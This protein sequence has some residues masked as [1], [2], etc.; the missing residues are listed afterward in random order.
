MTPIQMFMAA[1]RFEKTEHVPVAGA[2]TEFYM[3]T[4][5]SDLEDMPDSARQI[6]MLERADELFPGIPIIFVADPTPCL[7]P[8]L[9]RNLREAAD[10][11]P[12]SA[13]VFRRTKLPDPDSTPENIARLREIVFISENMPERLKEQYGYCRGLVRFE[14]P[15]DNL[16]E[17]VGSSDWFLKIKSDPDFIEAAMELFT[18]MSVAGARWLAA[19]IGAP[20]RVILAEDFPGMISAAAFSRFVAPFHRRIFDT[21]PDALKILHNDSRTAH[22]LD[23]LPS[24]GM[25]LFHFGYENDV[26]Q[27]K[28]AMSGRVALMGNI[29][30]MGVLARGSD[31]E[32]RRACVE[33]LE[34]GAPGGGFIFA[35]GGEVNPGTDPSRVR[36]MLDLAK[37]FHADSII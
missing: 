6:R 2:I 8:A 35:T 30:P 26:R 7:Y 23:V 25:E 19:K 10:G 3:S 31:E 24:C 28:K 29:S 22:L 15:F 4:I 11:G 16:V 18:E 37:G 20:D 17:V 5:T 36:L 34:A 32:V 27:T 33:V 21:F 12:L 13:D 1:A 14:N 9:I